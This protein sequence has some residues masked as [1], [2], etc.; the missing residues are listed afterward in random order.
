MARN[1]RGQ[2]GGRS[3]YIFLKIEKKNAFIL[4]K[5]L[6]LHPSMGCTSPLGCSALSLGNFL[7]LEK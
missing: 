1:F 4:G 7:C 6:L 2:V 5:M 3:P